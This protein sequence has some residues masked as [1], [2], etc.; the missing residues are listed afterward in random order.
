[1]IEQYDELKD[2][3]LLIENKDE[4]KYCIKKYGE[5]IAERHLPKEYLYLIEKDD[6]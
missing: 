5:A 6:E 2:E 1:M 4:A 3:F